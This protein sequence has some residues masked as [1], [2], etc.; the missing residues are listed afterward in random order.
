MKGENIMQEYIY[1]IVNYGQY[2]DTMYDFIKIHKNDKE[3]FMQYCNQ[4]KK[5]CG[6]EESIELQG[7]VDNVELLKDADLYIMSIKEHQNRIKKSVELIDNMQE[8]HYLFKRRELVADLLKYDF[9][10]I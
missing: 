2:E 6:D 4:S 9:I 3:K 5:I 1:A 7:W 8:R 10:E